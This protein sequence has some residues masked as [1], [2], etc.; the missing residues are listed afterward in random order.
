M[1][2]NSKENRNGSQRDYLDA[3]KVR[4]YWTEI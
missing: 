3:L 2:C 4:K 1:Y